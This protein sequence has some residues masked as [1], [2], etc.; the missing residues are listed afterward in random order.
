M[1]DALKKFI[2]GMGA[3]CETWTLTYNKFIEQG[4][5]AKDAMAHTQAFMTAFLTASH[6]APDSNKGE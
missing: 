4:Y 5:S 1:N 2:E 6:H 3:L